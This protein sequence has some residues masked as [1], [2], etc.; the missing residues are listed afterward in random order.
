MSAIKYRNSNG[1]YT[2]LLDVTSVLSR[3]SSLETKANSLQSSVNALQASSGWK[4]LTTNCFYK[5]VGTWC[6][7]QCDYISLSA[8][9]WKTLGTLPSGYRPVMT[10]VSGD[11]KG[12]SGTANNRGENNVGIIDISPSGSVDM[13]ATVSS[14][15]W[16][17]TVAFPCS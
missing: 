6:V 17:A 1:S 3:I 14:D 2:T 13:Y 5:K 4:K 16:T 12:I 10:G 15:Y 9:K 8:N 11:V 7:V